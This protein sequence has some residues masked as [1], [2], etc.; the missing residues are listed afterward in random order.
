M[1]EM[2]KCT[3]INGKSN[4]QIYGETLCVFFLLLYS[5][6]V[7]TDYPKYLI[8]LVDWLIVD[9]DCVEIF[10]LLFS[11]ISRLRSG[12]PVHV[13][14]IGLGIIVNRLL[15]RKQRGEYR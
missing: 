2:R 5:R 14:M 7:N 4:N 9:V 6:F 13:E 3:N 1:D 10:S 15:S 12:V 8:W 11:Y